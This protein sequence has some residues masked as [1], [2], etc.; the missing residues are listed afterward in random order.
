MKIKSITKLLASSAVVLSLAACSSAPKP[1]ESLETAR[2]AYSQSSTDANLIKHAQ[3]Q[4][5]DAQAALNEADRLWQ[6]DAER[7]N[8]EHYA[9]LA[10]QKLEIAQLVAEQKI[11]AQQLDT[12]KAEEQ[13]AQLTLRL[14]RT[15]RAHNK[16]IAFDKQVS[17]MQGRRT[18]RGIVATMGNELF[19]ANAG[20]LAST[21]D[22]K[23]RKIAEFLKQNPKRRAIIEGHTDNSGD[24]DFNLDLSRDRAYAVKTALVDRGIDSKRIRAL[25]F[26]GAA[27]LGAS[28]T[29]EGRAANHRVELTFPDTPMHLSSSEN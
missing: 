27:P 15:E 5:D 9:N 4:L 19:D 29:T 22:Y 17:E 25:G 23:L 2:V 20:S 16:A 7:A 12:K 1:V 13:D 6:N 28:D 8:V 3:P 11:A 24:A 10:S 26:G 18:H 14:A 21:A